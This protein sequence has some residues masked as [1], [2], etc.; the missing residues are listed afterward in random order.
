MRTIQCTDAQWEI[1]RNAMDMYVE[2]QTEFVE[3]YPD[4]AEIAQKDLDRG[5]EVLDKM[6]AELIKR[7]GC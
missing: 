3:M 2:N 1:I 4:T 5:I 7:S 6:N